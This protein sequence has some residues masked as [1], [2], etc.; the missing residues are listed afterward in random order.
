MKRY[1]I[2]L[3]IFMPYLSQ[4]AEIIRHQTI[5][6]DGRTYC[7]WPALTRAANGD[8]LVLFCESEEHLG[9][10]GR[11]LLMRSRDNGSTWQGPE[12]VYDTVIDD[13]EGGVTALRDGRLLAHVWSTHWQEKHYRSLAPNSYASSVLKRWIEHVNGREYRHAQQLQQSWLC[14]S[15]DHGRTWSEPKDGPDTVHGGVQLF[16]NSI[17]VAGYRAYSSYCG[18]YRADSTATGWQEIAVIR[19]PQP[20]SFHFGEPHLCQLQSG[21]IL[22]MIR[23]TQKKYDDKGKYC[24]LWETFSDDNGKTWAPPFRTDLWGFPPHLLVLDDGR[25]LCTYGYRRP[26]FGE[27]ACISSD[28]ISWSGKDEIILRDDAP[29]G[30]LGYPASIEIEPG[31]I[32]TVYYQP[33][34]GEKTQQMSPP[35]PHRKKPAIQATVWLAPSVR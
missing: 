15:R 17:L 19:S 4:S 11:I 34:A 8:L 35:D 3:V 32:L 25:V 5:Y 16:D 26:A 28:G 18:V 33:D 9:P 29:N 14:I 13:R 2:F 27:R 20:D 31:K 12:V 7:A 30:D 23:A 6:G 24:F 1:F 22:M 21:R 10:D